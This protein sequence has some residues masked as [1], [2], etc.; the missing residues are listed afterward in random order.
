[1]YN[2]GLEVLRPPVGEIPDDWSFE[3]FYELSYELEKGLEAVSNIITIRHS[4]LKYGKTRQLVE[5]VGA[6]FES[7]NIT[8]SNEGFIESVKNFFVW[9]KDKIVELWKWFWGL[10]GFYKKKNDQ[11]KDILGACE[12]VLNTNPDTPERKAAQEKLASLINKKIPENKNPNEVECLIFDGNKFEAH[13][14]KIKELSAKLTELFQKP[15]VDASDLANIRVLN[16]EYMMLRIENEQKEGAYFKSKEPVEKLKKEV[17]FMKVIEDDLAKNIEKLASDLK[18]V[19]E[20]ISQCES[21]FKSNPEDQKIKFELERLRHMERHVS[22]AIKADK[23][24]SEEND[25]AVEVLAEG[26]LAI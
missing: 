26:L 19:Q 1:M 10:F 4:V 11:N 23:R 18:Y 14:S 22:T 25:K 5:L 15:E 7:A 21:K 20:K 13:N 16:G 2:L 12:A 6:S 8:F 17:P 9:I 24:R 3:Q